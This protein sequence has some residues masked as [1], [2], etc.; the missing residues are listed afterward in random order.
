MPGLVTA[1]K[2]PGAH[3]VHAA[4]DVLPTAPPVVVM[5]AG[6]E[7]QLA[8]RADAY[9][10]AAQFEQATE[11]AAAKVPAAQRLQP[12]ANGVPGR[13]TVPAKPGAQI[14]QAA[15]E[16]LLVCEAVVVMPGGQLVQL[17][18]LAEAA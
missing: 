13:K 6:Q 11:P 2:Y 12:V 16:V 17:V 5:P 15:T 10:P 18:A 3:T 8:E 1:P 14:V 7:V 4:T 9:E